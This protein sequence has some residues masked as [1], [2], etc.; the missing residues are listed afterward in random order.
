MKRL[1]IFGLAA[2][3]VVL[4]VLFWP[5][6]QSREMV[7]LVH[8]IDN[9]D[10][11][12]REKLEEFE[13]GKNVTLKVVSFDLMTEAESWLERE[14][15]AGTKTIGLVKIQ[16]QMLATLAEEGLVMPLSLRESIKSPQQQGKDVL[17]KEGSI[18]TLL[19]RLGLAPA[20]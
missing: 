5:S 1:V 19:A 20:T 17:C 15:E 2:V 4:L 14:R 18:G 9:Q 13:K 7:I 10:R 6:S 12:F 11:W 3:M 8:M 16:K